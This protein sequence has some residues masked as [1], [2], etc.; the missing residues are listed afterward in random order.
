V[1]VDTEL[2]HAVR[3]LVH[4]GYQVALDDFVWRPD[5]RPLVDLASVVKLD[6]LAL[7]WDQLARQVER[8]REWDVELLAEKIENHRDFERCVD[9]GFEYFQGYFLCRPDKVRGRNMPTNK[10]MLLELMRKVYDPNVRVQALEQL[11]R[12]DVSLSY[13]LLRLI[14][15][16]YYGL[17]RKV[18]SIHDAMVLLGLRF[19]KRWVTLLAMAGFDDKPPELFT[20]AMTRAKMCE[21]LAKAAGN[22]DVESFFVVGLFSIL[23]AVMDRPLPE[24]LEDLPLSEQVIGALLHRA[25]PIGQALDC[26]IAHEQGMWHRVRFAELS[27]DAIQGA[28]YDAMAWV[29]DTRSL[30]N[31]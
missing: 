8:L 5:L 11:I 3:D 4:A 18:D 28:Y 12:R 29:S 23:D 7:S 21:A 20:I 26:V 17:P 30:L 1:F 9:L 16:A 6:V 2:V 19:V 22:R 13:R 24:V 25:G 31:D 27:A 10:L 14:N 15:S